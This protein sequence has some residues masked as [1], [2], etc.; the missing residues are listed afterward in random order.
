MWLKPRCFAPLVVAGAATS[1]ALSPVAAADPFGPFYGSGGGASSV[2]SDLEEQGYTVY[3]NWTTG[4]DTKPLNLC[5]VTNINNPSSSPP[6]P[7]TFT[8]VYVDVACPNHDYGNGFRGGIG[9]GIG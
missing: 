7:D 1:I 8:T 9:I 5:W 3:I 6:S 4:Y 2:I